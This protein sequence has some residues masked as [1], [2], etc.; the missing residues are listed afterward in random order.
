MIGGLRIEDAQCCPPL[1]T[2]KPLH[3]HLVKEMAFGIP[4]DC[5]P[6]YR[7]RLPTSQAAT[8]DT[9][10]LRK[11]RWAETDSPSA[12]NFKMPCRLMFRAALTSR[13]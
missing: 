2:D 3:S 7:A 9:P 1:Q 11:P 5:S 12:F 13:S 4:G 6:P 10:D 8:G